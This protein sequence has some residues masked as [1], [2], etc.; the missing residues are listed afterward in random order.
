MQFNQEGA[1][2]DL[3]QVSRQD[4]LMEIKFSRPDR[5]NAL[6]NEMYGQLTELLEQA[7]KDD[8]IR[9]LLITGSGSAFTAGNDLGEFLSNPPVKDDAPVFQMLR[10]LAANEKILIGAVNGLAVG[11]GT[12]MLLHCDLVLA[13]SG[14]RFQLPFINLAIVPE[15]ASSLLLPRLIGHQRAMELLLLAE[16]FYAEAAQSYGLV[17]RVVSAEELIPVARSVAK[18]ILQKPPQALRLLKRLV[19]EDTDVVLARMQ[20]ENAALGAQISSA[21]GKEA[22]GALIEKRAPKF[23]SN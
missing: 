11:I 19:A 8:A 14:A 4:G 7:N 9:C 17:N 6:S 18:Q 16:P 10:T 2:A 21:E 12:T 5:K 13:V 22:V 20:R 3:I 15:A 1:M 23:S